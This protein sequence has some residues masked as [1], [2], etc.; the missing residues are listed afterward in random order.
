MEIF[1]PMLRKLWK[2]W[3]LRV[4]VLLSLILQIVLIF[5]GNRRKY[6]RRPWIRIVLWGAYMVADWVAIVALG[7]TS[8]NLGDVIESNGIMDC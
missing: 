6:T 3:E 8:N 7:V 4:L 2:D 1:P 5:L